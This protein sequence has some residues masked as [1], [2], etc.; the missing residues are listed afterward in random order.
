MQIH[1]VNPYKLAFV[2]TTLLKMMKTQKIRLRLKLVY[3][4]AFYK[5]MF[6][7]QNIINF[8]DCLIDELTEVKFLSSCVVKYH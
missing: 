2:S 7:C 5:Q 3:K 6:S 1:E 4:K 8:N